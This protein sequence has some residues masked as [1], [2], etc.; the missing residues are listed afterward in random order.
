MRYH[1]NTN[2]NPAGI[3][4]MLEAPEGLVAGEYVVTVKVR[5][6]VGKGVGGRL[7]KGS[8]MPAA[9]VNWFPDMHCQLGTLT[10]CMQ[11]SGT[12]FMPSLEWQ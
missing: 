5:T 6:A 1:P 4:D 2:N 10:G 3:D 12:A 9:N 8:A 7:L 11:L